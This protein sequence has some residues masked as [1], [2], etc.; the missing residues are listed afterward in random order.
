MGE[1]I[2]YLIGSA[3]LVFT[4]EVLSLMALGILIGLCLGALPGLGSSIGIG[5]LLPITFGMDPVAAISMLVCIYKGVYLG[6]SIS[7]ILINTPG[8]A[9]AAAAALDG[10]PLSKRGQ[11]RKALQAAIFSSGFADIFSDLV[12]IFGSVAL[13]HFVLRFGPAEM[14]LVIVFALVMTGSLAGDCLWK[15]IFSLAVGLLLGT[16]GLDPIAAVPR[17][18][19]FPQLARLESLPVVAVLLGAFAFS[20][21]FSRLIDEKDNE[22]N[23]VDI[24]ANIGGP[25]LSF[26]E[27]K[28]SLKAFFLGSFLGTLIGMIP[29]MG[30]SAGAFISYGASAQVY[31]NNSSTGKF[32]EGAIPGVVAGESGNSAVSG[33][34]M[35]PLLTLGIPGSAAAALLLGGFMIQGIRPGPLL[36]QDHGEI[37][38]AIF[39]ALIIA[40]I[41]NMLF[42]FLL[43]KPLTKIL[44]FDQNIVFP[45]IT[46]LS[47]GGVYSLNHRPLDMVIMVVVGFIA[48][49]MRRGNIPIAP[50]VIAFVLSGQGETSFRRAL[51]IS[52]GDFSIFY[53]ST[54]SK[55]IIILIII[56]FILVAIQRI[57]TKKQGN[58][59]ENNFDI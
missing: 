21:I 35:L 31:N 55:I 26:S 38:F 34:N 28:E 29:G 5:V 4:F 57:K 45:A 44:K 8:T 52:G 59:K 47:L 17:F 43:I 42:G 19:I 53:Q 41:M 48:Y 9:G 24:K 13:I 33:A 10:Y 2:S 11:S 25:S 46:L 39:L 32:G 20:E 36:F 23:N 58:S 1:I 51:G 18:D 6:G 14:L 54:I 40:N 7:S 22:M 16:V 12:L 56:S 30:A 3:S 50:M 27:F 49:V 15:G 37:V